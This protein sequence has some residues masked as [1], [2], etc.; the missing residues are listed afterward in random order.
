MECIGFYGGPGERAFVGGH[1]AHVG[2]AGR[3]G[4]VTQEAQPRL[5]R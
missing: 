3:L 4:V 1:R 2:A 5:A